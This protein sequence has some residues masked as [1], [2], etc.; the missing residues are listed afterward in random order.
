MEHQ[1]VKQSNQRNN[2]GFVLGNGT[3]RLSLNHHNLLDK[4]I[5][6]A[7]NAIYRE[8]EP[9]HLI[10]VDVKMINEIVAS[11]Y[12]KTHSVWTNPNK[13][14]S[15]KHHLNM[16]NPHRGWS[17]G[18]TALWYASNQGHQEIYIFGFDHQGLQG[19][20][21][22]VYADT[23]NY[24]KSNDVATFHGNWLTQTEKTIKDFR[25]IQY[26]RVINPGDFIPDQLGIQLKNLKH[27]TYEEFDKKFPG[28]TYAAEN[29]QKTT[30]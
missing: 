8:F 29:V 13:G 22:N 18:P 2:A 7:C 16:F 12:H 27:I 15:T 3:S 25:N 19:K 20:F 11:G 24:K 1:Q 23:Y 30:I 6:Y 21:N 4:G 5:V 17:S 28:C 9:H 14:I 10:A 26:Y